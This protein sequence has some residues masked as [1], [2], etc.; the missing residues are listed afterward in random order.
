MSSCLSQKRS[1][2]LIENPLD[3]LFLSSVLACHVWLMNSSHPE[4]QISR[5]QAISLVLVHSR[6]PTHFVLQLDTF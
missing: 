1:S 5:L 4:L 2:I 6:P 3:S